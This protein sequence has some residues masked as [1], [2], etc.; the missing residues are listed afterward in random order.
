MQKLIRKLPKTLRELQMANSNP[1]SSS[2]WGKVFKSRLSIIFERLLLK[3][4]VIWSWVKFQNIIKIVHFS[5]TIKNIFYFMEKTLFV[6][7]IF[8]FL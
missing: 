2:I 3:F 4:E 7:E 1:V 6:L 5:K 8:K